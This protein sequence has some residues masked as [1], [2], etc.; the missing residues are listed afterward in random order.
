MTTHAGFYLR[1]EPTLAER[2]AG[3]F[4]SVLAWVCVLV[5][6]SL[7]RARPFIPVVPMDLPPIE[8]IVEAPPPEPGPVPVAP[9]ESWEEAVATHAATGAVDGS[10]TALT[11]AAAP[12]PGNTIE[13]W[14][15]SAQQAHALAELRMK[16]ADESAA[17]AARKEELAKGITDRELNLAGREFILNSDGG[18][19]GVI[20]TLDVSGH[21][22]D[23]VMRILRTRYGITV[24]TR[25][26][27][28]QAGRNFL[29][30]ARTAEGT[31]TT[32]AEAGVYDV[33]I[34]SAKARSM[35]ASM[36][37]KAMQ[38]EGYDPTTTRVR[39]IEFG[40]VRDE[41]TGELTLAVVKL[42][43]ERVR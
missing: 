38:A 20:R 30:A 25:H 6:L 41:R 17:I 16:L 24:E 26:V 13:T 43:A 28:P 14:R 12:G 4:V 36:E 11:I 9:A 18:T 1:P 35:M 39:E 33:F 10:D 29:N 37:V 21:D 15:P 40:M 34:L 22:E 23:E 2:G 8:I 5:L 7:G 32:A 3:A 19:Q 42:S 27:T 31:F